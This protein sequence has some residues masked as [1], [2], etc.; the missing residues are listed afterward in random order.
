MSTEPENAAGAAGPSGNGH[1]G[2]LPASTAVLPALLNLYRYDYEEF[3]FERGRLL[4]RGD[5]GTG[6][7]RVLAMQLPFLL[8]G[9]V[10]PARVEPDGDSAKRIEWNLLMGRWPDRTGYTWIEFGRIG[11]DGEAGFITLG[12]GLRAVAGHTGLHSRWF[13]VTRQRVGRDLFLQSSEQRPFGR[14]RL[15]QAIGAAGRVFT[16]A[17]NYRRAVDD[18]LFGLGPRYERLVDLLIRLRR[19]KLSQKLDENELSDTLSD[20]LPTLP[21]G[22]ID[23]VAEAFRSLQADRDALRGFAETRAAVAEFLREYSHY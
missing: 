9:E 21:G 8:D 4:L 6:K 23:E 15:E 13:F 12:C 17:Q 11:A 2:R 3:R 20:A 16:G 5:N 18:A 22:L 1:P 7:S 14:D 19:P 10:A